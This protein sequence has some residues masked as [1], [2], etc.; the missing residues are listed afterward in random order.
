VDVSIEVEL[1][2]L[3]MSPLSAIIGRK[4]ALK[5]FDF[6]VVI[7]EQSESVIALD[8]KTRSNPA[9]Y[10]RKS[11][12]IPLCEQFGGCPATVVIEYTRLRIR[13]NLSPY[14]NKAGK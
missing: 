10:R 12:S 2:L 7:S 4:V 14:E 8:Y 6:S 1:I 9:V 5:L 3:R 13:K 11:I